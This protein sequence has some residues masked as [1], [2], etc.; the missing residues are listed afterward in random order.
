MA[1][2]YQLKRMSDADILGLLQAWYPDLTAFVS[3]DDGSFTITSDSSLNSADLTDI[4]DTLAL[5]DL[6]YQQITL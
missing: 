4:Q 1:N 2:S 5:S 6:T 3:N